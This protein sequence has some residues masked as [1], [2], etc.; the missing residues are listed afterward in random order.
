MQVI[1]AIEL[2]S[3]Y[4]ILIVFTA[5]LPKILLQADTMLVFLARIS[6]RHTEEFVFNMRVSF[7]NVTI[8]TFSRNLPGKI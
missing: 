7:F 5:T 3:V 1:F 6:A 4:Y 2:I 8:V